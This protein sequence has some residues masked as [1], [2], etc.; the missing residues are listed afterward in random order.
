MKTVVFGLALVTFGVL[1]QLCTAGLELV[2]LVIGGAGLIIAII[3]M[4]SGRD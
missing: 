2:S 3:G 4:T 1:F